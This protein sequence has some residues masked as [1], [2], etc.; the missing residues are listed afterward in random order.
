MQDGN[1]FNARQAPK[2]P[3][4]E[5]MLNKPPGAKGYPR[6]DS[7]KP[8]SEIVSRKYTQLGEVKPET[9]KGYL[10]EFAD[11]YPTGSTVADVPTQRPGSG[12]QN[13][14]LAGE[15]LDGQMILEVPPQNQPIP[16]SVLDHAEDLG[17]IIRD[18]NGK[19]YP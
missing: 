15:K 5:V 6:V 9:A 17:I 16:K 13:A 14:G 8:G 7:Y 2:Y 18:S 19:V 11:T 10:N 3:H 4:N 1:D 12:H